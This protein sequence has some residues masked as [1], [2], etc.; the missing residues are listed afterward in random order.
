MVNDSFLSRWSK[1]KLEIDQEERSTQLS[2]NQ[3]VEDGS[4]DND[5]PLSCDNPGN[6]TSPPEITS[7]TVGDNES[8]KP[9][10]LASLLS[11][12]ANKEIKNAALRDL[13]LSGEFSEV[14]RMNDYAQD[15]SSIKPLSAEVAQTLRGWLNASTSNSEQQEQLLGE[16]QSSMEEVVVEEVSETDLVLSENNQTIENELESVTVH[17]HH[18]SETKNTI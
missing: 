8:E 3:A 10:S 5:S 6:E 1:R 13:F 2:D 12:E 17:N 4:I 18:D 14:C 16:S 9:S 7:E 15:F 11:S